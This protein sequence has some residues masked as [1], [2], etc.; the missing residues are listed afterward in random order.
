MEKPFVYITRQL[1]KKLIAPLEAIANVEMW[2]EEEKPV[3][4]EVLKEK[5]LNATALLTMLSDRIDRA[6]LEEAPQLKIVANLAVGYDNIDVDAATEQGIIVSNT[7]DVLSDTTAD[8]TFSLLLLAARRLVEAAEYIKNDQ[9]KGWSPYLLAGRDVHHKTIGIIGMGNIGRTVAKRATGFDMNI[10]YHNRSRDEKA[11]RELGATYASFDELIT[12]SDFIVCLTPLTAKTMNLFNEEA[13]R[14][15]KST[16]VFVNASRGAVV[17]EEALLK[18]IKE[19]EIAA[20]GLDVFRKE[21]I[22]ANDPLL[23][24]PNIVAL[25]HIGSSSIETRTAMIE[26]CVENIERVLKANTP[27]TIVN[28]SVVQHT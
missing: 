24:H 25:P 1:P 18:A 5:S 22:A 11:E 20:A 27:A 13:F 28:R 16:A 15:M 17:D 10:L 6:L 21:P 4:D 19:G 9:W 3:P 8:L 12:Q 2:A 14:K 23:T 7:P 26:L